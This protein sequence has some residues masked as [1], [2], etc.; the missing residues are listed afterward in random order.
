MQI[1]VLLGAGFSH[2]WGGWLAGEMTGELLARISRDGETSRLLRSN[3]NFELTLAALQND[4]RGGNQA[5]EERLTHFETA[6]R[7]TFDEMNR[8]FADN[9]GINTG[10]DRTNT[11]SSFL[12]RFETVYTLNQDLLLEL[13]YSNELTEPRK[14]VGLNFPGVTPPAQWQGQ[15]L[16]AK[17]VSTW[18]PGTAMTRQ[19]GCQDIIKLH[20]SANWISP[21]GGRL[22]IV[23]DAKRAAIQQHPL[24]TAYLAHFRSF[25]SAGGTRL[26]VVGYGFKDGHI[27]ELLLEA[28][29]NRDLQVYIVDPAGLKLFAPDPR[30]S[31]APVNPMQDLNI[32]GVLTRP[33][34]NAFE[35]D[36]LAFRSLQRFFE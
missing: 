7:D 29:Q 17:A 33:F 25:I 14:W 11:V 8:V 13:H 15:D 19:N 22:V 3:G 35:Q 31:I 16:R 9:G 28:S 36:V 32:V 4:A 30:A 23:G 20:G 26:M 12:A 21:D 6:I 1:G 34:R 2:N 18:T 24:L 27:N 10:P 5:A